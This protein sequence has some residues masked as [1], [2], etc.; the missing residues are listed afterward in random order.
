MGHDDHGDARRLGPI[1]PAPDRGDATDARPAAPAGGLGAGARLL[2]SAA[3]LLLACSACRERDAGRTPLRV[4]AAASLHAVFERLAADFEREH[5]DVDVELVFAGSSQLAL[6]LREGASADV[7]ASADLPN[8]QK[9]VEAGLAV[10]APREF[11][12]NRLAILVGKGNPHA[13]RTLADLARPELRVA[14]CGPEVPAGRYARD[15]L[16]KAGVSVRSLSDETN[17]K[18]LTSKLRLGE[19]DAGIA[20]R[21]DAAAD[22]DAIPLAAEHDVVA[23]Y[24]VAVLGSGKSRTLAQLFVD[25][26]LSAA[27][28]A[29]L[30]AAGF[31]AP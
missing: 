27:G 23:S 6:Q 16:A 28:R 26:L 4:F 10:G 24:P 25:H 22:L 11:A 31:E 3:L 13:V 5:P 15:A 21:T 12:R 30:E 18:A 8:L 20:Y 9:I 1:R 19:L 14:L 29:T 7:F 2:V 17:V